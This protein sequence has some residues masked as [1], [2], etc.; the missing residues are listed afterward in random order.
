MTCTQDPC[1]ACRAAGLQ[2]CPFLAGPLPLVE[3]ER[4]RVTVRRPMI[5][6]EDLERLRR[7]YNK[8]VPSNGNAARSDGR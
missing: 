3:A 8:G 7:D 2:E 1:F 5:S 6:P 4:P